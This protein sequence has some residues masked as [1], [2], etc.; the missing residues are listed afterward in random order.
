M[1]N[2]NETSMATFESI[3]KD[4]CNIN[5][6]LLRYLEDDI[7]VPHKGNCLPQAS[8]VIYNNEELIN[9]VDKLNEILQYAKCEDLISFKSKI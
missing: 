7:E 6:L 3:E 9:D 2:S 8:E 4:L 5:G 1:D